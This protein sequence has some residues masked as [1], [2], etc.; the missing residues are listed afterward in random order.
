MTIIPHDWAQHCHCHLTD[1]RFSSLLI[2]QNTSES[3]L[4]RQYNCSDWIFHAVFPAPFE[5]NTNEVKKK[6][7]T[8]SYGRDFSSPCPNFLFFFIFLLNCHLFTLRSDSPVV[9]TEIKLKQIK[10]NAKMIHK[11]EIS[12]I[13]TAVKRKLMGRKEGK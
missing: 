5:I 10:R 11:S 4:F 2:I 9:S 8:C 7:N 1:I 6:K 3:T 13:F 12:K